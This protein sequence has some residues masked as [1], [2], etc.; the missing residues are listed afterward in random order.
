MYI[1]KSLKSYLN[2]LAAKK[3]TPGGGSAAAL[4]GALGAGLLSMVANF[5]I[6]KDKFKEV[7]EEMKKILSSTEKLRKKLLE[8]VDLDVI[9]YKQVCRARG[10]TK[11][12]LTK[13]LKEAREVTK[14]IQDCSK[15]ALKLSSTLIKKGNI[16]LISDVKAA[17]ILLKASI[18]SAREFA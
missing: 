9:K 5:T 2:D 14:Q 18:N 16:N 15:D 7:E 10:K 6:G 13:A 1:K 11:G 8:L 12:E 17:Q 3:P 4:T